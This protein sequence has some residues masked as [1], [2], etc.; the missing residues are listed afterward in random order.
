MLVQPVPATIFPLCQSPIGFCI[1]HQQDV[2]CTMRKKH[3]MY[4]W[5]KGA[6]SGNGVFIEIYV[7][8]VTTI[9]NIIAQSKAWNWINLCH[10]DAN[11]VFRLLS[12]VQIIWNRSKVE[13]DVEKARYTI[14]KIISYCCT[15]KIRILSEHSDSLDLH[16]YESTSWHIDMMGSQFQSQYR[17]SLYIWQKQQ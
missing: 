17:I 8:H 6:S 15:H 10:T 2:I 9:W 3:G 14:G 4:S 7:S 5:Q 13:F 16:Y 12:I 11:D 1:W